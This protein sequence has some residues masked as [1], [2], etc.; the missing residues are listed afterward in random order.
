MLIAYCVPIKN[1]EKKNKYY[2][3][4]EVENL[5]YLY[6]CQMDEI[7]HYMQGK[8]AITKKNL[9]NVLEMPLGL[10]A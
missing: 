7:M 1:H 6:P 3:L 2:T 4:D 10:V 8:V 5:L 9:A